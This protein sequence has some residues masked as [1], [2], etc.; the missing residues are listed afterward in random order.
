MESLWIL[1][2]TKKEKLKI[3]WAIGSDYQY[4]TYLIRPWEFL[5]PFQDKKFDYINGYTS[6]I[7]LFAKFYKTKHCFKDVCPTLKACVV[8]SEMLLKTTKTSR[9]T[10]GNSN[11]QRVRQN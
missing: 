7:V 2:V 11:Y 10:T 4:L 8:T 1:L 3:F 5:R 6:S 9:E